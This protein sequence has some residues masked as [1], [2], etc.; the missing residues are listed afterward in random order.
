MSLTDSFKSFVNLMH[1]HQQQTSF[2]LKSVH[3]INE[4]NHNKNDIHT[5]EKRAILLC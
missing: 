4:F 3:L 1:A 5:S 2:F